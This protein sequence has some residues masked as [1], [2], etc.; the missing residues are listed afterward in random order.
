MKPG[1]RYIGGNGAVSDISFRIHRVLRVAEKKGFTTSFEIE[2]MNISESDY[3]P[4]TYRK[5]RFFVVTS[6]QFDNM[7]RRGMIKIDREEDKCF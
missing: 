1:D 5:L 4:G 3:I 6:G 2:N 7:I